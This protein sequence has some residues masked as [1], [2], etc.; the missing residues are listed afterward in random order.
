[1]A[2]LESFSS[3]DQ[4]LILLNEEGAEVHLVDE[5][6]GAVVGTSRKMPGRTGPNQDSLA[7]IPTADG[8]VL[9]VADGV[10][11]GP[12][13]DRASRVA[14]EELVSALEGADGGVRERILD[15]FEAAN[16]KII[17]FG[18]GAATTLSVVEVEISPEGIHCRPY[19]AG[20]SSIL[21]CGGRGRVKVSIVPHS[22]VGYAVEAGLIQADEAIHHDELNIVSNLVGMSDM[23]IDLGARLPLSPRDTVAVGTDGL[24]DNLHAQEIVAAVRKGPIVKAREHLVALASQRMD[25]REGDMPSKPDDM[26]FL[27]YRPPRDLIH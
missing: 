24:F 6:R 2:L 8:V 13:G 16:R 25:Q 10:G 11:G 26:A 14:I 3:M 1:M 5:R 4:P 20:D 27:L 15:A 7:V 18:T 17:E 9:A 12:E 23:R 21:V 19:H 22:P